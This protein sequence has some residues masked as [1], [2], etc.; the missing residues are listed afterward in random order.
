MSKYKLEH[1][2]ARKPKRGSPGAAGFD[3]TCVSSREWRPGIIEYDTGVSVEID[4][5]FVGILCPRSSVSNYDLQ[6]CNS[7]GVIDSD[8]RGTIK[9]R[10]KQTGDK[11]YAIGERV[12][13]IIFVPYDD[14]DLEE[15]DELSDTERGDGGFGSSTLN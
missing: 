5:G 2:D 7:V 9:L 6:L 8:Y 13:Q 14:F 3:L 11:I 1:K 15:T 10:F 4:P 12:G